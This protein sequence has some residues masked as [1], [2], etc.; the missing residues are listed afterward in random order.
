MTELLLNNYNI[1]CV[2]GIGY[3]VSCDKFLRIS[4]G[5]ESLNRIKKALTIVKNLIDKT[6]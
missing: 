2:A 3:G 1:S 6:S 4:I 5:T